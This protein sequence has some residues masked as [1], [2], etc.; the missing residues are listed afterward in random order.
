LKN[1]KLFWKTGITL[2]VLVPLLT[3]AYLVCRHLNK[4]ER[5]DYPPTIICENKLY[6]EE[7][8]VYESEY[9]L[10]DL[11]FVGKIDTVTDSTKSPT[12]NF[13]GNYEVFLDAM[14]YKIDDRALL[15]T[16][17]NGRWIL[18][19]SGSYIDGIGPLPVTTDG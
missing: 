10:N 12:V 4:G 18:M 14:I 19:R 6:F 9:N 17:T 7:K 1:K 3:G 2:L 11:E 8:R 5:Y 15:L 13:Q 16:L